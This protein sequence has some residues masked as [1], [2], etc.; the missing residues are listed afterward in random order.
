MTIEGGIRQQGGVGSPHQVGGSTGITGLVLTAT[1]R[2]NLSR[3]VGAAV[4]TPLE[5]IGFLNST[6]LL[7]YAQ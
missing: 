5:L 4:T 6:H 2:D 3:I 7:Y 1:V